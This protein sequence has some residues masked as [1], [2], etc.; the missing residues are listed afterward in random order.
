MAVV[1]IFSIEPHKVSRDLSGYITYIYGPA[2]TGKT[3]FASKM[4]SPLILALEPGTNAL[5]GVMAQPIESWSDVKQVVRQLKT[6]KG[7][8]MFKSVVFDPVDT[9]GQFCEKYI[10][11][12]NGVDT[13]SGIPYG[14]GWTLV[15]RE[16]E[17]VLRSI[18][19][20]GYALVLI[21]HDKDKTFKRKDGTEYNQVVPSCPTTY[22]DISKNLADIY[23]FAE[24]YTD[25]NGISRVRLIIR[26][27]DNSVDSGSRFRYMTPIIEEFSYKNL[28]EALNEAIDKEAAEYDNEYV[29]E[30][31]NIV[32]TT[33]TYDYDALMEEFQKMVGELM[34]KNKDY[35]T[36]R[37]TSIIEKYLGKGKKISDTT[38]D[39]AEF[40]NLIVTEVKEDLYDTAH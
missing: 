40:V 37:I 6:D 10:C 22:N 7:H 20:M 15:K 25:S 19:Q 9:A 18:V 27:P 21:S 5:P 16:F 8:E 28:V 29:T 26:S 30:E 2:K 36:P 33:T 1:D 12:Q 4:P 3:T 14:Q 24:K 13:L 39:Q 32:Q 31:R 38:I 34:N 23:A 17:G 11:S 35:Y